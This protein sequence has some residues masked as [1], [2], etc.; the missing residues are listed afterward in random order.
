AVRLAVMSASAPTM[1]DVL[2]GGEGVQVNVRELIEAERS[3]GWSISD[4]LDA[5]QSTLKRIEE[6]IARLEEEIAVMRP[7][8][9][10]SLDAIE[11]RHHRY[12]ALTD[13]LRRLRHNCDGLARQFET[14]TRAS[15]RLTSGKPRVPRA[16]EYRAI[17]N[18]DGAPGQIL[19]PLFAAEDIHVYLRE[20]AAQT[21]YEGHALKKRL[22]GAVRETALIAML[23]PDGREDDSEDDEDRA[24]ILLRSHV[25][26]YAIYRAWLKKSY[27]ELFSAQ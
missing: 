7:E 1:I 9:A 21:T 11:P 14:A 18:R 15:S 17:T 25:A 22:A 13:R 10:I 5:P 20:L 27:E 26:N 12:F 2:P 6:F 16:S 3:E 23:A 4:L 24:L 8:G 19:K